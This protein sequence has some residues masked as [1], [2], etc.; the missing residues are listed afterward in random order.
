MENEKELISFISNVD[1]WLTE[2][3]A[4]DLYHHAR[5]CTGKGVI[6]EIG[7][8]KGKSTISLGKGSKAGNN[9]PVYAIDPHTGASDT[10]ALFGH[11][12]TFKEFES[13]IA[14]ANLHDIVN[15]IVLTSEEAA[16]NFNKPIEFI[17]IDGDH[18][19]EFAKLDFQLWYPKLITG[20]IMAFH[21]SFDFKGSR[22]VVR[23][24]Q[25]QNI[26]RTSIL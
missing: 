16:K 26:L 22:K 20:G 7:S 8:W 2:S 9:V 1:G 18:E 12:C 21:D 19:Y 17:F 15:P 14:A 5:N 3:E 4:V 10:I 25:N 23:K 6:V 11:I 13:N 24:L